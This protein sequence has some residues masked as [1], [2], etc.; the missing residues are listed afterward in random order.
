MAQKLERD[1]NVIQRS[2]VEI[3]IDPLSGDLD[4]IQKLDDEPN[5]VGGLTAQQL[6]AKFDEAGNTIKEYINES[7][8]PQV[9]GAD[10]TE[11]DRKTAEEQRKANEED[12]QASEE[13]RKENEAARVSAE[14]DRNV[15]EDY[16]PERDYVPGNKVYY[17]GSSYVNIAACKDVLP[18]VAAS[19]QII[20]KKGADS[21]EG[22]SQEEGDLRYLKL[23]G[24]RMT[25]QMT[26]LDPEAEAN[27]ATKAYV[28][29]QIDDVNDAL[30]R[31]NDALNGKQPNLSGANGRFLGFTPSG[32]PVAED[33]PSHF[34]WMIVF[35]SSA[36]FSPSGY[37]LA[38]GDIINVICVGGGGSGLGGL[39]GGKD[40]E[41][42]GHGNFGLPGKAGK[43]FGAGGG[44][45]GGSNN[46][47]SYGGPG[48]GSG[49]VARKTIR[50]TS[51]A[52]VPVTVGKA[53]NPNASGGASSFGS[54]LSAAGGTA[55]SSV[56]V[57]GTG[58]SSGGF[59]GYS[60]EGLNPYPNRGGGAGGVNESNGGDGASG[61]AAFDGQR[62]N[63]GGGGGGGAG[64]F[65]IPFSALSEGTVGSGAAGDGV[66][67]V[68]W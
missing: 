12:R 10:A 58:N 61:L 8:I 53:G 52:S 9:V 1:L 57:P 15:W 17:L 35:K 29:G 45:C 26:V 4:I 37:G 60:P 2:G 7:L 44:G 39:G 51:A 18:T 32:A 41:A 40:G 49:V 23:E 16:S 65:E 21:D 13:T 55:C 46:S 28:D 22:M 33:V 20:A 67:V 54:H 30:D 3:R 56:N 31:V 38:V 50:L 19:W 34:L 25:G 62:G 11:A 48:G 24:G 63:L 64:G 36:A 47:N 43:G 68:Y 59:G 5:D 42:S 66:V 14:A 27:P 6:K